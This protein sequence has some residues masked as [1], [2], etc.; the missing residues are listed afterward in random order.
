MQQTTKYKFN[1][2][3]TSDSFGP[4]AL[5]ANARTVETELARV[6]A[7][8]AADKAALAATEA[9]DKAALEKALADQKSA[10]QT[11]IG[12]AGKTCRIATGSYVGNGITTTGSGAS[13][14]TEFRP[15]AVFVGSSNND[16]YGCVMLRPY[17]RYI[18]SYQVN[19]TVTWEERRVH[20]TSSDANYALN[21][22]GTTYHYVVIGES[23]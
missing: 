5:N 7:A 8:H 10:L 9:A 17:R 16:M 13:I 6:E 1:I 20:W 22:K 4:D 3:E 2:I 19:S 18:A 12:S 15:L 11:A 23:L 21:A 14:T